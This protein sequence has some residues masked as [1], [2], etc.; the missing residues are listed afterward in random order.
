IDTDDLEDMD[1]KWQV[2]KLTMRVKRF[3]KKKGRNL[4]FSG[5]ETVGFDKTKVEYYNW[6]MRG[7]F[8]RECRVPRNQGTEMEIIQE[9]LYLWRL[10]LMPWLLLMGWVMIGAFRLKKDPHT[11]L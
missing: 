11:L 3:L 6:H 7:Y 4:N 10:L 1:L 9:G 2:A 8:A 5:K